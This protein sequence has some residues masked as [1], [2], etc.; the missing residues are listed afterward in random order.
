MTIEDIKNL[1]KDN[2]F[3]QLDAFWESLSADEETSEENEKLQR[4][5]MFRFEEIRGKLPEDESLEMLEN[6]ASWLIRHSIEFKK[7][8]D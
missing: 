5:F 6:L 7:K 1:N 3:E 2:I 4:A 8:E